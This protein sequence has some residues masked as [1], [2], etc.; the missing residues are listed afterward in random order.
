MN[1]YVVIEDLRLH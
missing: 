1:Y